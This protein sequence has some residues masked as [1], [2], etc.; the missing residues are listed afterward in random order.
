MLLTCAR[1]LDYF[2]GDHRGTF[3]CV[4]CSLLASLSSGARYTVNA[5]IFVR[6]V[7]G[8]NCGAPTAHPEAASV[9]QRAFLASGARRP[10]NR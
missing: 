8:T 6:C 3:L 7:R 9:T 1:A 10:I 5:T 2:K 4:A